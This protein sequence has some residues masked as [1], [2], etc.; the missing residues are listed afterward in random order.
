[1]PY[2]KRP[3]EAAIA[4]ILVG[5]SEYFYL[6]HGDINVLYQKSSEHTI[7]ARVRLRDRRHIRLFEDLG[8]LDP[9]VYNK[10][11][12]QST[13]E[14]PSVPTL[15]SE[16]ILREMA[17]LE[18]IAPG[19]TRIHHASPLYA[20]QKSQQYDQIALDLSPVL[21]LG[22]EKVLRANRLI[23]ELIG[24]SSVCPVLLSPFPFDQASLCKAQVS[25]CRR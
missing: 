25:A 16:D 4:A 5:I 12:P 20:Q 22:P 18:R 9:E 14:Q 17:E 11:R 8:L 7:Q 10:G 15:P 21:L 13:P 1:M 24:S 23:L 6:L 2:R 19:S 3:F